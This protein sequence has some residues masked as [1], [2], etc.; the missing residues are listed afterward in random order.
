[1]NKLNWPT[2]FV[3]VSVI[4][5]GAFIYNKSIDSAF[6]SDG[7]MISAVGNMVWQLRDGKIRMCADTEPLMTDTASGGI[8][9]TSWKN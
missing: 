7:D 4:F 8:D 2:A 5:S 1:M 9:C 3:I 6:E